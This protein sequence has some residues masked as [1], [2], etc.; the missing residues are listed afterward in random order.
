M[1]SSG[2]D[3]E[4]ESETPAGTLRVVASQVTGRAATLTVSGEL[5]LA[6]AE[7]LTAALEHQLDAG[8]RYVRL[9]LSALTFCDASGLHALV[10][11]HHRFLNGRG[12]LVLAAV[13]PAVSR[14]LTLTSLDR[15]LFLA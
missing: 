1:R 6:T 12:T 10:A 4:P 13:S 7:L 9:N 5:D 15:T 2:K 14:L 3:D 8:R 11:A